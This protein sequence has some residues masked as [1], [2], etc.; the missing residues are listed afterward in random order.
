MALVVL[1]VNSSYVDS[2]IIS[3]KKVSKT[4]LNN[5]RQ[6]VVCFGGRMVGYGCEGNT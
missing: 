5:C 1:N 4:L 6:L 3:E 2:S